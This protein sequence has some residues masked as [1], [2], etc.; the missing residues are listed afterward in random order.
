M[1]DSCVSASIPSTLVPDVPPRGKGIRFWLILSSLVVSLFLAILESGAIATALP[2]IVDSLHGTQF[3]WIPSAYGLTSTALLPLSGGLAE[4]FGRRP[5]MLISLFLF[6]A[7]SAI[8]G[9]SQSMNML[10]AARAVQ[11]AGAGGIFALSQII[12]S[13]LVTLRERGTYSGVF[14][15]TWAAAG[16]VAPVIGGG[17]VTPGNWRWLFYLNVPIAAV[18]FLLVFFFLDLPIPTGTFQ[19]KMKKID[20]LGSGIIIASSCACV[21]AFTWGGT[22]YP[23]TSARVMIPLITGLCGIV[24]FFVYELCFCP[25]PI[26]PLSIVSNRTSLSGYLQVFLCSFI[27]VNLLYYLPIYYQACHSASPTGSGVSIFG[28]TFTIAPT[29]ILT[30]LSVGLTKQYRPQLWAGWALTAAGVGLLYTLRAD[31][32]R[33]ASV[34]FQAVAGVGVGLVYS[35]GYF[36]VLA[37]LPVAQSALALAFYTF[38]RTLAQVWAVAIGGTILQNGLSARLP[39][40]FSAHFESDGASMAYSIIPQ[41][42]KLSQPLQDEVR[43][44]YAESISTLWV[45]L[46]AVSGLGLLVSL[47]MNGL[48]LHDEREPRWEMKEADCGQS[49]VVGPRPNVE[50]LNLDV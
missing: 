27:N 25:C 40:S 42:P 38:L 22:V 19:E 47:P 23:W 31:T 41:I 5:I 12:L 35:T 48:P 24:A 44:A 21:L 15:L 11:G 45:V 4:V 34:G 7:G 17:L 9:A 2:T 20:W 1:S 8:G 32:A 30:G 13:D 36:P 39:E 26:V 50:R 49:G 29:S 43:V 28:L 18:S 16:G 3:L 10:I 46:I 14:G 33:G 6:A 37:P